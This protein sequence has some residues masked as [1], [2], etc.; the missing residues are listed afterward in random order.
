MNRKD[1][2][3]ENE[4]YILVEGPGWGKVEFFG[5]WLVAAAK[6]TALW[7][8]AFEDRIFEQQVALLCVPIFD[9]A[10][11]SFVLALQ[12]SHISFMVPL[13]CELSNEVEELAMM[14]EM[15]FFVRTGQ[16][17]QMAIPV[18]LNI[19]TV[20]MAALKLAE[21]ADE[22]S[23]HLE[24]LVATIPYA[25]AKAW[26]SRQCKLD[27]DRFCAFLQSLNETPESIDILTNAN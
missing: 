8:K 24:T 17:Y 11:M 15:G 22:E 18:N 9:M 27:E 13:N 21:T 2:V 16:H 7:N 25:E 12:K 14:I 20:K 5:K 6:A 10:A 26:Q 4:P 23:L 19:K 1:A 3:R